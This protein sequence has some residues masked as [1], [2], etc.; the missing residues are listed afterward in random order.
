M[1]YKWFDKRSWG[2]GLI[3]FACTVLF[4]MCCR[5]VFQLYFLGLGVRF[6]ELFMFDTVSFYLSIL[7]LFLL[8]SLLPVSGIVSNLSKGLVLLR[9]CSSIL[10]YCCCHVLGFWVFYELSILSLLLLLI[11]ESPYSE[12]FVAS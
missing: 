5:G 7:S 8:V 12:R 1:G 10:R 3:F 6:G 9:V 2:L 11:V 4:L